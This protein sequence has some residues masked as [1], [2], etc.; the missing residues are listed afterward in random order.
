MLPYEL[1]S[2]ILEYTQERDSLSFLLTCTYYL[3]WKKN[4][5]TYMIERAKAKE[6]L[7]SDDIRNIIMSPH[8][9][10][11]ITL[12]YIFTDETIVKKLQLN[13]YEYA[14][15]FAKYGHH[16]VNKVLARYMDMS[17]LTYI[18]RTCIKYR[19]YVSLYYLVDVLLLNDEMNKW[20]KV[21]EEYERRMY[22][23]LDDGYYCQQY[24]EEKSKVWKVLDNHNIEFV[25]DRMYNI[26][27]ILS[28][29]NRRKETRPKYVK[30]VTEIVSKLKT[31][32]IIK[33]IITSIG[34][35]FA[36]MGYPNEFLPYIDSLTLSKDYIYISN[37]PDKDEVKAWILVGSRLAHTCSDPHVLKYIVAINIRMQKHTG[38]SKCFDCKHVCCKNF[39]DKYFDMDAWNNIRF[40][41]CKMTQCCYDYDC[42]WTQSDS[43]K[44]IIS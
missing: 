28:Y 9:L 34:N 33:H 5:T 25:S 14:E 42:K 23:E 29:L 18:I 12:K 2:N 7:N 43:Y 11:P 30:A 10:Y 24:R 1:F 36:C 40:R 44:K 16:N 17:D 13:K 21:Q 26:S 20:R 15:L 4:Y 37:Y 31:D 39:C 41:V 8:K 35:N 32:H 38:Y 19:H 3:Q 22:S 27:S 6:L